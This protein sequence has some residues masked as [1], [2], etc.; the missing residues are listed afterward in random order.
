MKDS[1]NLLRVTYVN[2]SP[3]ELTHNVS[4]AI[5]MLFIFIYIFMLMEGNVFCFISVLRHEEIFQ[6]H[7]G[8]FFLFFKEITVTKQ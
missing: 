6:A 4:V 8:Y 5:L 2:G 7:N 1:P 3:C